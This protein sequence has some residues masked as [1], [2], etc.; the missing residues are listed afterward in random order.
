MSNATTHHDDAGE[1]AEG[2]VVTMYSTQWCGYCRRLK[3]ALRSR[4]VAIDEVDIE[5][6]PEH[7]DLIEELTGG[8]R[9]VPTVKIGPNFLVNPSADEVVAMLGE[10]P[11]PPPSP[12]NP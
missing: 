5:Q 1:A 11:A 6:A 9:T 7:G 8:F 12:R 4:G 10:G 3:R 2:P